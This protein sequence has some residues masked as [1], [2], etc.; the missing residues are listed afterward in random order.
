MS[1]SAINEA[2]A[3]GRAIVCRDPLYVLKGL[4]AAIGYSPAIG[5]F[6]PLGKGQQDYMYRTLKECIA[7]NEG[8]DNSPHRNKP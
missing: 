2:I 4:E 1:K 8:D 7:F 3:T 6:I 5:Y